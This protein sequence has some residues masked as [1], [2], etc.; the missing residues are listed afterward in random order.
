MHVTPERYFVHHP[1]VLR[2]RARMRDRLEL[3]E[4]LIH[5]DMC[6]YKFILAFFIISLF[7]LISIPISVFGV[8]I[9]LVQSAFAIIPTSIL[10]LCTTI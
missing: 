10:Y 3:H 7:A 4:H 8:T 2:A 9:F 6:I 1:G 5:R